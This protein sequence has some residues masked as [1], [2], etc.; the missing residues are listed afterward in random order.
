MIIIC[1]IKFQK[2][3]WFNHVMQKKTKITSARMIMNDNR[4]KKYLEK[5]QINI[6]CRG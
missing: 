6:G 1:Y 5:D 3:Q 4:R 2:V